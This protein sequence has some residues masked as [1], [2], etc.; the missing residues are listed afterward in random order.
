MR[1]IMAVAVSLWLA[2]T[3]LAGMEI[4]EWMYSGKGAGDVGEFIELTN[5]GATTI[6]MTGWSFDDDSRLAGTV[7]LSAFG[8]VDPGESVILTEIPAATFAANWGLS[9]VSI[10][11]DNATNLGRNDEI[12]LYDATSTLIDRLTYGDQT[13]SGTVR[14]QYK[15]CNIPASGYA[16]TIVQPSWTLAT[17]NDTFGSRMSTLGEVAS[18]GQL[19]EPG[20]II[21]WGM[22]LMTAA[23]RRRQR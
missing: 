2:S 3:A 20:S 11:G 7:S 4:T 9:G 22:G 6:D 21:L 8:T 19:P 16:Q 18:P 10:I 12:N 15:S 23:W 13:Y 17:V 14:T 1:T 5:G